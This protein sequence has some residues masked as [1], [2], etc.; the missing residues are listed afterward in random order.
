VTDMQAA[1][2]SICIPTY[3]RL[4]YL[5]ETLENLLPQ[6][7]RLDIEVCV[8]D[9]HSTD[10]TSEFLV[11]MSQRY[12]SLRYVIQGHNHG[13]EKNMIFA[14]KMASG[15]YVLPI[16]DDEVLGNNSF[17]LILEEI[18]DRPDV[19]VLDGWDGWCP[20]V[21]LHPEQRHL[22]SSLRGRSFSSPYEAFEELW[23]RMSPGAFLVRSDY[24]R[25]DGFDK[26]I[27]T[28]HA[29]SGALWDY[30]A[31][32][33][34]KENSCY[35]KCMQEPTIFFRGGEKS[36]RGIAARVM[37]YQIPLW[38]E[39]LN[40]NYQE[41]VDLARTEHLRRQSG[42]GALLRYRAEGQLSL[43][44]VDKLMTNFSVRQRRKARIVSVMPIWMAELVYRIMRAAACKLH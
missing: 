35:I 12:K 38:F 8:S 22:P 11:C 36:W 19:L 15:I 25:Y 23:D 32:L 24:I 14:L 6:T 18:T 3:N 7:D 42:I 16:G 28:L 30:L 31:Q 21:Q 1:D 43:I 33:Y 20:G 9:N 39:L 29:Y 5:Q 37:L 40:D 2:I 27:G 41:V 34:E 10:G 4:H 26:Y 44:D 17:T 13:L